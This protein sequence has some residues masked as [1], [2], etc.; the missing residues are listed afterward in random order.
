MTHVQ[1]ILVDQ[2]VDLV[3]LKDG[4]VLGIDGDSVMLHASIDDFYDA[5]PKTKPTIYLKEQT[6]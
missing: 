3:V 4:R 1:Q 6:A 5:T 2:W